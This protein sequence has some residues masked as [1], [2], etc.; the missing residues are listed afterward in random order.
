[1]SQMFFTEGGNFFDFRVI[2]SQLP[3][4][5]IHIYFIIV[6]NDFLWFAVVGL[7]IEYGSRPRI[8]SE[9]VVQTHS[10]CFSYTSDQASV[11]VKT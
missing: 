6:L 10:V 9:Q 7:K 3:K 4:L 1:M 2:F 5:L 11:F 8:E